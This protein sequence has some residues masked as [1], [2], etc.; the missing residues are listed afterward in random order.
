[1]SEGKL[2]KVD[3]NSGVVQIVFEGVVIPLGGAW[4]SAGDILFP[5][6]GSDGPTI[7]RIASSGSTP[8][9]VTPGLKAGEGVAVFPQ[10]LPDERQFIFHRVPNA[11]ATG[12][13]FVGSLDA[14]ATAT[15]IAE[16][17]NFGPNGNTNV[18]YV[19]PGFLLFSRDRV[20]LAQKFDLRHSV[21]V[22][23]PIVVSENVG[24][25]SASDQGTLIYRNPGPTTGADTPRL[26]WFDRRG[27]AAGEV[28]TPASVGSVELSRDGQSIAIDTNRQQQSDVWVIDA[29]GVPHPVTNAP[30]FEGY[31]VWNPSGTD[32]VYAANR[33][34]DNGFGAS[35]FRKAS[36]AVGA[37][38]SFLSPPGFAMPRDWS[39]DGKT[40]VFDLVK[41]SDLNNQ[42]IWV[43]PMS[44]DRKPIP[45]LETSAIETQAQLSPD[46]Q[47][48][49]YATN[50]SGRY[51]IVVR[52][53]PD[54]NK[55]QWTITSAGGVEPRWRRKDGAELYYLSLEGKVMAVP[56][57][58]GSTFVP[59]APME[60]FAAPPLGASA[61]PSF[62]RYDVTAEGQRFIFAALFVPLT[63]DTSN[64]SIITVVN[65][66]SALKQ[67]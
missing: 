61:R 39:L 2:R 47:Y 48:L 9:R 50:E 36:N 38:E 53:F 4:N 33:S 32:I 31:P 18:R 63:A 49:A 46:G 16:I 42:D 34:A 29:R 28:S 30:G 37:E 66:T 7:M 14:V 58:R 54:P 60:L 44:G 10:F 8:V 25:F 22:G 64:Q 41:P 43:L 57:T 65:W 15:P 5:S 3:V 17:P 19:A 59:G 13:V 1:M 6:I 23:D 45:F 21:P 35:L 40:V 52:T 24:F 11:G 12:K 20:L 62:R 55:G 56:I 67:K 27:K 51:Q 26:L